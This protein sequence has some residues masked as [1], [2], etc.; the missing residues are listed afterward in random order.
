MEIPAADGNVLC[1][2]TWDQY[3][4][5]LLLLG[6]ER[7]NCGQPMAAAEQQQASSTTFTLTS[8][9]LIRYVGHDRVGTAFAF[10]SQIALSASVWQ[11]YTQ[12]IWRSVKK[13]A[14]RMATL[15][16][17]FGADTSV[18]SFLNYDMIKKFK[19]GYAIAFFAW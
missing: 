17:I 16:D 4:P 6:T 9:G 18:L 12:W 7:H 13:N 10:L 3:R 2:W 11:T 5:L 1:P 8:K 15:N 19:V 14:M